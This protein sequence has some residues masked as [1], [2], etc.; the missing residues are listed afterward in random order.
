MDKKDPTPQR[1]KKGHI[2]VSKWKHRE[3]REVA[4]L[5]EKIARIRLKSIEYLLPCSVMS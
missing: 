3:E 5:P 4:G 2:F 1:R